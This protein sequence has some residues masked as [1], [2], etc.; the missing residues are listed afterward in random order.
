L[1]KH[2]SPLN[3]TTSP[4]R[5]HLIQFSNLAEVL[6]FAGSFWNKHF[7]VDSRDWI[8]VAL[9]CIEV[10]NFKTAYDM[11]AYIRTE[12]FRAEVHKIIQQSLDDNARSPEDYAPIP[13][14]S[15]QIL[16]FMFAHKGNPINVDTLKEIYNENRDICYDL[17]RNHLAYYGKFLRMNWLSKQDK[18]NL[19][20][21]YDFIPSATEQKRFGNLLQPYGVSLSSTQKESDNF[22]EDNHSFLDPHHPIN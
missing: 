18:I 20:E 9:C 21:F 13:A 8:V 11:L 15:V 7:I 17:L 2:I 14:R 19:R 6:G 4:L 5:P 22:T 12:N 3:K 1:L 10:N 16:N